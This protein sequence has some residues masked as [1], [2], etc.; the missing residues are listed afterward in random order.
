SLDESCRSSCRGIV[1]TGSIATSAATDRHCGNN[2]KRHFGLHLIDFDL[3]HRH[4]KPRA[5]YTPPALLA[6]ATRMIPPAKAAVGRDRERRRRRRA[7]CRTRAA[8]QYPARD[9][10]YGP[11]GRGVQRFQRRLEM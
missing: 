1:T 4:A 8:D 3:N 9:L 6:P 2:A 11:V 7:K 10:L 5:G